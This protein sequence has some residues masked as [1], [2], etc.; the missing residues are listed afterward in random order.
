MAKHRLK[1]DQSERLTR[2]VG[3]DRERKVTEETLAGTDQSTETSALRV[4]RKLELRRVVE[5]EH[6]RVARRPSRRLTEVRREDRLGLDSIVAEES[7]RSLELRVVERLGKARVRT[8]RES[9]GEQ[10]QTAI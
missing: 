3:R 6:A 1:G 2:P 7:I 9:I 8:L 4:T 5:H 10:S